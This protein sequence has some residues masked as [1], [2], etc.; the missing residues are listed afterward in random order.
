MEYLVFNS[1]L[2]AYVLYDGYNREVSPLWAWGL[3]TF[4]VGVIVLPFYFASRPLKDG[5]VRTGGF[6]W[7]VLSNFA[8]VWTFFYVAV[9]FSSCAAAETASGSILAGGLGLVF[10]GIV[11]FGLLI[12]AL[13]FGFF[14]KKDVSEKGPTGPLATESE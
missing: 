10:F 8:L 12:V 11:W 3:G 14:I 13:V 5:E 9:V 4:L 1:L 6:G 7:N 2:T